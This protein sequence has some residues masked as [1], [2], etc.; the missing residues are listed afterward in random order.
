MAE[1]NLSLEEQATQVTLKKREKFLGVYKEIG[2]IRDA[3]KEAGINRGTVYKWLNNDQDFKVQFLAAKEDAAEKLER[4]AIR[5]AAEGVDKPVFYKGDIVG[6]VREYSDT[7][8]IFLLKGMS[9][10]KYA[11]RVKQEHTISSGVIIL[12]E[13][14]PKPE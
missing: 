2:I 9:P 13:M 3:A 6:A 8:L 14:P 11:D 7:L 5:R 1:D 4:E 10:D 12:P